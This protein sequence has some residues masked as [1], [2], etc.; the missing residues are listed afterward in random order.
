MNQI[1]YKK[2]RE[3]NF[4][5][6]AY[7][8]N[9]NR[10]SGGSNHI[11]IKQ[12]GDWFTSKTDIRR[13]LRGLRS[14]NQAAWNRAG[15]NADGNQGAL[16]GSRSRSAMRGY[17]SFDDAN[18]KIRA[19]RRSQ[20]QSQRSAAGVSRGVEKPEVRRRD[21]A[22]RNRSPLRVPLAPLTAATT[23]EKW[24]DAVVQEFERVSQQCKRLA[25]EYLEGAAWYRKLTFITRLATIIALTGVFAIVA[26]DDEKDDYIG[27]LVAA[28]ALLLQG[29]DGF[30]QF[31]ETRQQMF[32]GSIQL[33]T[34]HRGI[35]AVLRQPF[36]ERPEPYVFTLAVDERINQ[37]ILVADG[38][39]D[40]SQAD[41]L[42]T[43]PILVT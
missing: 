35:E 31:D 2:L 34:M 17:D 29:L 32:N 27:A 23:S 18:P 30:Y 11:R 14:Q 25:R 1:I 7:P 5:R 26:S 33:K 4:S 15:I 40:Q 28:L 24:T 42:F 10:T 8:P 6:R 16:G 43:Q 37:I 38:G 13:R 39:E 22:T 3:K 36:D 19:A 12:M 20:Q 9:D 21:G 41:D